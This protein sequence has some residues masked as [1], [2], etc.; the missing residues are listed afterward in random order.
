VSRTRR[1]VAVGTGLAFGCLVLVA[2][3]EAGRRTIARELPPPPR[4]LPVVATARAGFVERKQAVAVNAA[5]PLADGPRNLRQGVVTSVDFGGGLVERPTVLYRVNLQ[6]VV[7]AKGR[8]P[9]FRQLAAGSQGDDVGQLQDLLRDAGAYSGRTDGIFSAAV[10]A[11]V[12]QWQRS[13][14]ADATGTLDPGAILYVPA[15]PT[16][17]TMS[18]QLTV[19]GQVQGGEAAFSRTTGD[20]EFSVDLLDE[21][22]SFAQP[23]ADVEI[24][25]GEGRTWRARVRV[26]SK[27]DHGISL[28]LAATGADPICL[29]ACDTIALAGRTQYR[30]RVVLLP[31]TDGLVVPVAALSRDADGEDGLTLV[32]GTRRAVTV[33]AAAEGWAVVA[34]VDEGTR[35]LVARAGDPSIR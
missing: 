11:A 2:G 18:A 24:D 21:Q 28:K 4:Q 15:L 7:V 13:I 9:S 17:V 32:D 31:R 35:I 22:V 33:V 12:T 27:T 8:I 23:D 20:P 14:G 6:P 29:T 3:F 19:G 30:A 10:T 26:V 5:W 16:R 25:A 1:A 34:G